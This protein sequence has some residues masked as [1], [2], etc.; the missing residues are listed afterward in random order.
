MDVALCVFVDRDKRSLLPRRPREL[1]SPVAD[2]R[3]ECSGF[4]NGRCRVL[5]PT[6]DIVLLDNNSYTRLLLRQQF[7]VRKCEIGKQGM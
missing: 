3:I 7:P 1:P 6:P 5:L 2:A 4:P